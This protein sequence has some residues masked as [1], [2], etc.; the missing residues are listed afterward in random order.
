M[1]FELYIIETKNYF[2]GSMFLKFK[3]RLFPII[4]SLVTIS[5]LVYC[6][7]YNANL[8]W[9]LLAHARLILIEVNR[10]VEK[11]LKSLLAE[12]NFRFCRIGIGLI[13]EI[14]G[15]F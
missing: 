5:S 15:V 13:L 14:N 8:R 10:T 4:I 6:F 9:W 3:S 1:V 11:K 12:T 2:D 7:F